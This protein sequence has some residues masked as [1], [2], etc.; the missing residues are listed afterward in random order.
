M[1]FFKSNLFSFKIVVLHLMTIILIDGLQIS[2]PQGE[3]S[4]I[5]K[6]TSSGR[7]IQSFLGIPFAKP[8]IGELRFKVSALLL[9]LIIPIVKRM[10]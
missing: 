7:E 8:P 10:F 4:G 1:G 2:T 5:I 6:K 9:F 3:I